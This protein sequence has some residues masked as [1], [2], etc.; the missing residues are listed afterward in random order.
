MTSSLSRKRSKPTELMNRYV[1]IR[2][3]LKPRTRSL[4]GCCSIQLSYRTKGAFALFAAKVT[5][6]FQLSNKFG[7]STQNLRL[8]CASNGLA[9]T[10]KF[11]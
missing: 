9:P 2:L 7:K 8:R 3:G 5:L 4:E 6:F 1:V 10:V 11:R